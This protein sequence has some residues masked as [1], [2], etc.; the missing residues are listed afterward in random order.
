MNLINT[1]HGDLSAKLGEVLDK[2]SL[3]GYKE[4]LDLLLSNGLEN[5]F[6]SVIRLLRVDSCTWDEGSQFV[7]LI[8]HE[9]DERG[10]N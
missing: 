10:D 8:C 1:D 6:L 3:R 2:E 4:D 5:C 9:R 7:K